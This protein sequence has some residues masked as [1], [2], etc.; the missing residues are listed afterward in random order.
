MMIQQQRRWYTSFVITYRTAIRTL[1]MLQ[2]HRLGALVPF[3]VCL[4][5]GSGLLWLV[6]TVAPL[7]PF[8]Y[9]LF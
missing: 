9:S 2:S 1:A 4:L 6:N 3:V 5:V 7:A 8:V